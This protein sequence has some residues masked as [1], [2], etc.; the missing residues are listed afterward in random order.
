MTAETS[1]R[2]V[3]LGAA[4]AATI[5]APRRLLAMTDDWLPI[6]PGDAGFAPGRLERMWMAQGEGGQ[7]L[8]I[9]PALQLVIAMTAGN[10]LKQDQG[11]PPTR[12]LREVVLGSI[13]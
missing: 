5:S 11:I 2:D 4:A 3:L 10:Y 9:I 8:F 13:S 1:R 7:R 6:S 12:V